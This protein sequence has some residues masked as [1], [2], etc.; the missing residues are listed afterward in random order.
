MSTQIETIAKEFG[1]NLVECLDDHEMQ[2]IIQLNTTTDYS[3][4]CATHNYC[5]ANMPMD[6]AFT[7]VVG[8]EIDL[9][10]QEDILIWNMAWKHARDNDF[11]YFEQL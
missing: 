5:D 9:Q 3:D 10:S 4:C 6:E 2:S 8:R 1:K 11:F 7:K